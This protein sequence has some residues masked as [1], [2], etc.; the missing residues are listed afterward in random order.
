MVLINEDIFKNLFIGRIE[1][2]NVLMREWKKICNIEKE[3]L[4]YSLLNTPGIGKTTLLE[5]FGKK[6]I[7]NNEGISIRI[8]ASYNNVNY[9]LYV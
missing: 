1:E 2:L 5:Y 7:E 6:I 8:I 3:H 4:V 9:N